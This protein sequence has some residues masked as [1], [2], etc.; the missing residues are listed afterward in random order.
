V[1]THHLQVKRRTAK[2]RWPET[3]VLP[4]SHAD[5]PY[6]DKLI[7]QL[8]HSSYGLHIGQ[9]FVG[10]AVYADD[11]A[12]MSAS[13]YGLQRL[14][15]ICEQH[16][17]EWDIQFNPTKTQLITFAGPN[18]SAYEIDINVKSIHWVNKIIY[19][20]VYFLCNAGFT[21]ITDSVGKFCVRL[22]CVF[23]SKGTC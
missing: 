22:I 1:V 3:G 5:K 17:N 19:L 10:C 16:N 21:D 20:G 12:L 13:C 23:T 14:I 8:R 4:L 7:T 11:I 2:E 6:V 15:N 9:L 18:P